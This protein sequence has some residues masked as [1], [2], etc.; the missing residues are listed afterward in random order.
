MM[1]KELS[2]MTLK[3]L[4]ELF[5]VFLVPHSDKWKLYY[6]EIEEYLWDILRE[7]RVK[8][9]SHIGSTA[10][11]G[12][13][14]KDIVDVLVELEDDIETAGGKWCLLQDDFGGG[15]YFPMITE[16]LSVADFTRISAKLP[17]KAKPR[18]GTVMNITAEE[19]KAIKAKWGTVTLSELCVHRV[20]SSSQ[21]RC[22]AG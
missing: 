21:S 14:A 22:Y 7:R 8:R 20:Y 1:G 19:Y 5:P 4:W 13:W 12:I 15:G 3:E 10:I 6:N 11:Y 16:D 2:E 17:S 9:I 18:H